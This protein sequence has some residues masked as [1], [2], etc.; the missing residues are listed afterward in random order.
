MDRL[1]ISRSLVTV[2]LRSA[3]APHSVA[4]RTLSPFCC[5]SFVIVF[6]FWHIVNNY[7]VACSQFSLSFFF[8]ITAEC[9]ANLGHC[10]GPHLMCFF[11]FFILWYWFTFVVFVSIYCRSNGHKSTFS[12]LHLL[13]LL[14]WALCFFF[15]L[16][17]LYYT[18]WTVFDFDDYRTRKNGPHLCFRTMVTGHGNK[19]GRGCL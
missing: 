2:D 17:M 16:L 4:C 6:Q 14:M 8:R 12:N 5:L 11:W 13:L 7:Y 9:G 1:I 19:W 10:S 15:V 3:P 18:L